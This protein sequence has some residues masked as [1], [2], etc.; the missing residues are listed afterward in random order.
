MSRRVT[1]GLM[2]IYAGVLTG[3]MAV[4]HVYVAA[5]SQGLVDIIAFSI[6]ALDAAAILA[7]YAL[8]RKRLKFNPYSFLMFHIIAYLITVGSLAVHAFLAPWASTDGS[9]SGGL[10]WMVALWTIG[11]LI[12]TFAAQASRGFEGVEV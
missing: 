10:V 6:L 9:M 7:F 2:G 3:I 12:H 5:V 8:W 11:L 4:F 1:S